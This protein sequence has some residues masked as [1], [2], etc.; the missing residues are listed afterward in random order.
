MSL[1]LLSEPPVQARQ[2][3]VQAR[4][5]GV[6]DWSQFDGVAGIVSTFYVVIEE[7]QNIADIVS[8]APSCL[9]RAITLL[10]PNTDVF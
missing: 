7:W 1:G 5:D 4:E 6:F 3:P 8:C 10:M 9:T 2:P